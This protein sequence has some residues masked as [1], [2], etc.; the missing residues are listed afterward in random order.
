MENVWYHKE[1]A[2]M[3]TLAVSILSFIA[4]ASLLGC[5]PPTV[6]SPFT[7][8]PVTGDQLLAQVAKAEA[9]VVKEE[10][11]DKAK[12]EAAVRAA[13][14]KAEAEVRRITAQTKVDQAKREEQLADVVAA[15]AVNTENIM[16]EFAASRAIRKAASEAL[17]AQKEDAFAVLQAEDAKRMAWANFGGNIPIVK[18]LAA[19]AGFDTSTLAGLLIGGGGGVAWQNSRSRKRENEAKEASR[20][21]EDDLWDEATAK[22]KAEAD[23]QRARADALQA[24]LLALMTPPPAVAPKG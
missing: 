10:A 5:S 12:A 3:K 17:N 19:S 7:G 18:Q 15:A 9:Q 2:R 24:Q 11:E 22:T 1:N 8:K 13:T 20:K 23:A 14:A 16:A 21:R 6:D 4:L